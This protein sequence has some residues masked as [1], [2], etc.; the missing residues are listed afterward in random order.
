MTRVLWYWVQSKYTGKRIRVVPVAM[1]ANDMTARLDEK[2]KARG[3]I[4]DR[5]TSTRFGLMTRITT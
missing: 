3:P 1:G 5:T 4:L 2:G